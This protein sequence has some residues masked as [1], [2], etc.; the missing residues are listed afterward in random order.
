ME[1]WSSKGH[2]TSKENVRNCAD[3]VVPHG[4]PQ[5]QLPSFSVKGGERPGEP[6]MLPNA[7]EKTKKQTI[8]S[9]D[10]SHPTLWRMQ[11]KVVTAYDKTM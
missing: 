10:F 1:I 6:E 5:N 2:E 7:K 8:N 4:I 9:P 11:A 3:H